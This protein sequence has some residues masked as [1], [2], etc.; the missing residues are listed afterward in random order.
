AVHREVGGGVEGQLVRAAGVGPA[1]GERAQAAVGVGLAGADPAPA[2][3][4]V[5]EEE[6]DR[7]A[8][9][10]AAGRDVEDVGGDHASSSRSLP[11][12]S[13]VILACSSAAVR[14]SASRSAWARARRSASID[15]A[16]RPVAHTRKTKPKRSA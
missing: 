1:A 11:S 10:G 15:S 16:L 6:P 9:R 5:V 4:V 8:P 14:S 7:N 2:P 3:V 12:R 13:R